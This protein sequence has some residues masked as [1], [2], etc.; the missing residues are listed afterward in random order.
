MN[1]LTC[2]NKASC[3]SHIKRTLTRYGGSA[4]VAL[5]VTGGKLRDQRFLFLGAGSAG[6][7]IAGLLTS[8]MAGDGL[9]EDE[10]R[11]R[12]SL[13]D[14]NGLLEPGRTDL[15]DFQKPYAHPHPPSRDFTEVIKSVKP[16]AIIGVSTKGGAFTQPVIEAMADV[17]QRPL[18]F[19]LS[20]ST[21]HAECTPEQAYTWSGGRAIYAAGVQFPPVRVGDRTLVPG[22]ANNFYIFPAVG[23]AIFA[24]RAR[25]VTDEMFVEAARALADQVSDDDLQHGTVYPPQTGILQ[26]EMDVAVR[27]ATMIFDRGLAGVDRPGDV[28]GFVTSQLYD[29]S[30]Q[31]SRGQ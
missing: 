30:D 12:V 7:G 4:S 28:R 25:R 20:N 27:V 2:P 9:T 22:Q 29:P 6:I 1:G 5:R 16:T 23:L 11:A 13:F 10:A 15:L 21:D 14:V 31:P 3:A 8:A 17:S 26:T 19:A 18:I 24:T